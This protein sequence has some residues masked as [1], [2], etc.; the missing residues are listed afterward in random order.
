[1]KMKRML[2][3]ANNDGFHRNFHLPYIKMFSE[4]GYLVDLASNGED[5]FDYCSNKFNISFARTPLQFKNIKAYFQMRDILKN[6]FYNIIYCNT[7]VPSAITRIA[8]IKTRKNGS[9]IIYSAHGF[10]FYDG[11]G[12]A[13]K[14]IFLVIEKLLANITD[15]IITMNNEDYY[16]C[17]KHKFNSKI[18]NVNGV[19]IQMNEFLPATLEEKNEIRMKNG[20]SENDFILIYPAELTARKNQTLLFNIVDKLKNR[21]S[22]IKLLLPGKGKLQEEYQEQVKKMGLESEIE[23]LGYR[24]DIPNLLRMSDLLV[25]SS[26]TEGL[27]INIIEA[28][29]IGLPI[30]A[31][32]VRGHVDL[33]EQDK[34]GFLFDL[35]NINDAVESI[36][37]LYNNKDLYNYMKINAIEKSK[38]Y[39]FEKVKNEYLEILNSLNNIV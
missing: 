11:E 13:K 35:N 26:R 5:K 28:M 17:I 2:I 15:C 29:S 12:K 22:N 36:I 14:N 7:P 32:K 4:M 9:K 3:I 21:N 27:P 1:M 37:K 38:K 19:G 6:N 16:N 20:Y 25:A 18:I 39:D 10:S 8:A 23:F 31:T 34:H 24:K 33:I 30:V